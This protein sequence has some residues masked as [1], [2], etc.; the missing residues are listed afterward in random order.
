LIPYNPINSNND[1]LNKVSDAVDRSLASIESNPLLNGPN[2]IT[3]IIFGIGTDT[4]I[5][6][7]MN[8]RPTGYIL[9]GSTA[10]ASI[11]TS[12]TTN[13]NFNTLIILRSNAATTASILFF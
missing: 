8:R 11:Y 7:K 2:L 3:G 4:V 13:T 10:A 6:H 12:P 5:A 1:E 9:T